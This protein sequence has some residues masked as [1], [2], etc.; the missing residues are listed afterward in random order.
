M[1]LRKIYYSFSPKMRFFIRKVFF[2][3]K[4]LFDT[5]FDKRHRY[6]PP[7][8]DIYIGSGDF[9][10]QGVHQLNLLIK[11][12]GL[13]HN[14]IVL[15]IGCGMGR[16]AV[17]LTQYLS[18]EGRYEGFDVVEKGVKWCNSK[19]KKDFP[20]FN[21]LYV[22]LNNDLY[23]THENKA[24]EFKFPY[25]DHTFDRA[26]LFSVFTHMQLEDI[27]HYMNEIRR[28]LKP[29]GLCLATCFIYNQDIEDE[30]AQNGGFDFPIS[31]KGYRLMDE[32]VKCANIAIEEDTLKS[33]ISASLLKLDNYKEGYWKKAIPKNE[34]IDFQDIIV[35]K[36]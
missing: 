5:I 1:S 31:K 30:I 9:I 23:N 22:P 29:D 8:G 34:G 21:F 26:F 36:K 27:E 12:I 25:A 10:N 24:S 2:L 14:H 35:L 18:H 32:D 15:D 19:I 33:M 4:D 16:T 6:Q 20:N 11:H 28:V 13:Q 7:K 17:P 3:P